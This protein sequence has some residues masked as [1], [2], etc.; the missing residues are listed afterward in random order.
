M[1]RRARTLGVKLPGGDLEYAVLAALWDLG[2]AF[3]RDVHTAVGEPRGLLYT[4]TAKVLD[5]LREKRLIRRK[6]FGKTYAYQA[7]VGRE[8][9]T[10][11][12]ARGVVA[13]ILGDEPLP[14]M[15]ALVDAVH[16]VDPDLIEELE[17]LVVERRTGTRGGKRRGP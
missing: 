15:V 6:R 9:V 17:R 8:A 13:Q 5:R 14:A 1:V 12:R 16:A 11:A 3:P 10:R 4:T 7:V 2:V